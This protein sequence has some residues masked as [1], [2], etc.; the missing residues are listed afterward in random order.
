MATPFKLTKKIV[1]PIV[2]EFI[3]KDKPTKAGL[4]RQLKCCQDTL[5]RAIDRI[6]HQD[7]EQ[8]EVAKLLR[9]ALLYITEKHEERLYD[10]QC[11][12]SI[13]YLKAVCK[14]VDYRE[15]HEEP[16][17]DDKKITLEIIDKNENK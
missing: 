14:M 10:K 8:R 11:V 4:L 12:G 15:R 3:T 5:Y 7:P 6:D 9:E 13:F 17:T 2:K 16:K 1:E